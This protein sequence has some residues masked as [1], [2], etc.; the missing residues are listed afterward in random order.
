MDRSPPAGS[1]ASRSPSPTPAST[2]A[3][4]SF[5]AISTKSSPGTYTSVKPHP[6]RTSAVRPVTLNPRGSSDGSWYRHVTERSTGSICDTLRHSCTFP[7]VFTPILSWARSMYPKSFPMVPSR[8]SQTQVISRI[9]CFPDARCCVRLSAALSALA[10]SLAASLFARS[11]VLSVALRWR[12]CSFSVALRWRVRSR[13]CALSSRAR[14]LWL[15]DIMMG[16]SS[17]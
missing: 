6:S 7:L 12:S 3:A 5:H 14:S 15:I 17:E 16:E 11:V 4:W 8:V 2:A 1:G 9:L 10:R 13:S